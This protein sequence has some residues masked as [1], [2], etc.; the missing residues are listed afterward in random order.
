MRLAIFDIDGALLPGSTECKFYLH[1]LRRGKQ[2]P[3]QIFAYLLF[4]IRYFPKHGLLTQKL[5][6]AYLAGL[7]VDDVAALASAF[8]AERLLNELRPSVVDRLQEH[9]ENGDV[10]ML[11][12]GTLD[13]IARPLGAQLGVDHVCATICTERHGKFL[14]LPPEVHP[15]AATKASLAR[16]FARAHGIALG[17]AAAYA[18]SSH[19]LPL[20]EAVGTPVAVLP[21]AKLL[22]V[23]VDRGW[24]VISEDP[25]SDLER[26]RSLHDK[27]GSFRSR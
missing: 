8:V 18:D 13:C 11:M 21:D 25:S 2:G 6:K 19:D 5:N 10:V 9:L 3:R 4:W 22:R 7:V 27:L 16:E 17:D 12:S 24:E 14:G 23:A 15:F 20:L 1:L 26:R